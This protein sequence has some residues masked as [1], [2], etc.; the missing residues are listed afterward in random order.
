MIEYLNVQAN[1]RIAGLGAET[2]F[3]TLPVAKRVKEKYIVLDIEPKMLKL[4][5]E[6]AE[7]EQSK[8]ITYIQSDLDD[9]E[10]VGAQVNKVI[11]SHVLHEVRAL[12]K[13]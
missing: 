13:R 2:G 8:N 5:K 12:I 11:I 7:S 10:L 1:D 4:L 9:L 3:F 6:N